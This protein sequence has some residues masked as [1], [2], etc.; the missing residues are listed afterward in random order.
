[1]INKLYIPRYNGWLVSS[2]YTSANFKV[3]TNIHLDSEDSS[4][5]QWTYK[6]MDNANYKI[7]HI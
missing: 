5:S 7:T 4:K 1:M 6:K 3:I 2:H